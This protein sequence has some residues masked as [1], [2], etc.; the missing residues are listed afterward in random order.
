MEK[1]K[2]IDKEGS[3]TIIHVNKAINKGI[4]LLSQYW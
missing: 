1:M 3:T 4:I 2:Q